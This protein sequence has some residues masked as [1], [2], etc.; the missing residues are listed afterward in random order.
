VL[1]GIAHATEP[2]QEGFLR[3]CER[4]VLPEFAKRGQRRSA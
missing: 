3:F 4:E 1:G 2:D